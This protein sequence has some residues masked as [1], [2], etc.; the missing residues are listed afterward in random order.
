MVETQ[1]EAQGT[2]GYCVKIAVEKRLGLMVYEKSS[3]V[4]LTFSKVLNRIL[5]LC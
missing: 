3:N 2:A 4:C 1:L 5:R